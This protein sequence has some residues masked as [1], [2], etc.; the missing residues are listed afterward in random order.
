MSLDVP[1]LFAM[2]AMTILFFGVLLLVARRPVL[3][4]DA[5][6]CWALAMIS[7]G[8]GMGLVAMAGG[9][10][11]GD[12][13]ARALLLLGSG[14]GWSAATLFARN[15]AHLEIAVL[16]P[17]VWIAAGLLPGSA[18]DPAHTVLIC[19]MG[20]A[21]SAG[22]GIALWRGRFERLPSRPA[23]YTLLLIHAA[24]YAGRAVVAV[25]LPGHLYGAGHAVV[26]GLIT[27]ALLHTVGM[28]FVLMAMAKERAEGQRLETLAA[29][30]DAAQAAAQARLRFI[31]RLS[32]ELRTP[33]HG[34]LGLAELLGEDARLAS[35][36]RHHART[37]A[38][39]GRHVLALVND[40]LDLAR[41][42]AGKIGLDLRPIVLDALVT[43]CIALVRRPA[44]VKPVTLETDFVQPLPPAVLGDA[45]RLRQVLLNLLGNAVKFTPPGGVVRLRTLAT[46][47]RLRFE[48]I[49]SGP[50]VPADRRGDLFGDFAR[51]APE[52]EGGGA[53]L[54]LAISAALVS[55]MGGVI[56]YDTGP[57][58]RGAA[59]SVELPLPATVAPPAT[60][61]DRPAEAAVEAAPPDAADLP[62][63]DA[64]D[65]PPLHILVAD[66]VAANRR[67]ME[68]LLAPLGHAV[69]T[70][71]DGEAAVRVVAQ[72]G[73][74]VVLMD[75][76]MP[77]LDGME[78]TRRIRRAGG[79]A[80]AVVV[81][82]MTAETDPAEVAACRQSGMDGVV[83]KPIDRAA[84]LA[85]IAALLRARAAGRALAGPAQ[86]G[87]AGSP[88]SG[89]AVSGS[90]VSTVPADASA[91]LDANAA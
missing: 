23:A 85:E 81:L 5:I 44:E 73:V 32:H 53:G 78:A 16:G 43:D 7:G 80:G 26:V 6:G 83:A 17:L 66:D 54:G 57:D 56:G 14:L 13:L 47:S 22:A 24:M 1:T 28:A 2:S 27:E 58:G 67:L 65:L 52:S 40:V 4:L 77:G 51:F 34:M 59:F 39:A 60:A 21:Y 37:I 36:T 41:I 38:Q 45:T 69:S 68:V 64:A 62:P 8:L 10:F 42:D 31:G 86:P 61:G 12:V 90:P 18:T 70:A 89:S 49:D 79:A 55:A 15:R 35:E 75:L 46:G 76:H 33:L 11:V 82:G 19:T 71:A 29:A 25:A 72:G 9:G 91:F 50:G 74:D 20:A 30:R 48:V 84:L 3:A 63:P 87:S 88:V